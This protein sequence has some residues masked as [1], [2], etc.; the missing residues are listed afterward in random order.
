MHL[1]FQRHRRKSVQIW[2]FF[3]S[4]FSLIRTDILRK[5]PYLDTFHA[6]R[7]F[8]AI[9][10]LTSGF[11]TF[12]RDMKRNL[13]HKLVNIT[14][15]K[16]KFLIKDFFSK[17]DQIRRFLRIWSHLLKKSLMENFH[18]LCSVYKCKIGGF[19]FYVKNKQEV[20]CA[21]RF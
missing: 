17:Y 20:K 5:S 2:S 7:A 16:L 9:N 8:S 13:G 18:F 6:V 14:A 15:Q 21:L 3:W 11:L 12:S 1:K 10:I 19:D 4:V